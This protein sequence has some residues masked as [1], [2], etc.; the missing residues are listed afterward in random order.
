MTVLLEYM[1]EVVIKAFLAFGSGAH[2]VVAGI[3]RRRRDRK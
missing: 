2:L 1:L 3:R